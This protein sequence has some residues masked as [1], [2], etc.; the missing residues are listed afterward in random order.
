MREALFDFCRAYLSNY[1]RVCLSQYILQTASVF[2]RTS[3]QREYNRSYLR[4]NNVVR[5]ILRRVFD[6][7]SQFRMI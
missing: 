6:E 3:L 1:I 7:I 4:N 5:G 2:H